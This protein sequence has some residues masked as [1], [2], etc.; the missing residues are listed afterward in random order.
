MGAPEEEP[1][2]FDEALQNNAMRNVILDTVL[3][4]AALSPSTREQ[5]G[6]HF[7]GIVLSIC[8]GA[9]NAIAWATWKLYVSH[10]SGSA[11]SIGLQVDEKH[12]MMGES[13]TFMGQHFEEKGRVVTP[14]ELVIFFIVGS[15]FS[16]L[17]IPGN[18]MKLGQARYDVVLFSVAALELVCCWH[19]LRYPEMLAIAMGIQNAMITSWSGAVLRTTHMTGTGTDLGS[20]FG[21]IISRFFRRYCQPN[22]YST[23]DWDQHM[24]D[25]KK[26]V[27]MTCLLI[28][29]IAGGIIGTK[30]FTAWKVKSLLV[31]AGLTI[32]L[33]AVH[34]VYCIVNRDEVAG[35]TLAEEIFA[36]QLSGNP[37]TDTGDLQR[38]AQVERF[39][40]GPSGGNLK[41]VQMEQ[42]IRQISG[43]SHRGKV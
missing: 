18:T 30:A 12:P 25:R 23:E 37:K 39:L 16:G 1:V 28:S 13:E 4:T 32:L 3:Q 9:A 20:S 35:E 34:V 8:A 42:F 17:I 6:V 31:P 11:T 24:V 14:V 10:V 38:N 7:L 22:K 26:V 36:R 27:L 15:F 41:P 5:L 33:G 21:R 2:T 40:Q 19:D 29:F 43:A